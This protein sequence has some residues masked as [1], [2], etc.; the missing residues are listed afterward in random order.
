[1]SERTQ[2]VC[3]RNYVYASTTGHVIDFKKNEPREVPT[4]MV[5]ELV[6][7]GILPVDG[8]PEETELP[9]ATAPKPGPARDGDIKTAMLAILARNQPEEFTAAGV[10]TKEALSKETGFAVE[11][12]ER[13]RVWN[14]LRA[15]QAEQKNAVRE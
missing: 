5:P 8:I 4:W 1:M 7:K 10:P 3:N 2:V 12:A 6:E 13:S 11:P 9:L 15:E 14:A